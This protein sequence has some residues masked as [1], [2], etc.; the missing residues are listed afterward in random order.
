MKNTTFTAAIIIGLIIAIVS[1]AFALEM[2][3]DLA[4]EQENSNIPLDYLFRIALSFVVTLWLSVLVAL[5]VDRKAVANERKASA[6][7]TKNAMTNMETDLPN[8]RWLDTVLQSETDPLSGEKIII[9]HMNLH[10]LVWFDKVSR[11]LGKSEMEA[12]HT[13]VKN[14]LVT[15]DVTADQLGYIGNGVFFSLNSKLDFP[16]SFRISP[17]NLDPEFQVTV[18][19]VAYKKPSIGSSHKLA[20]DATLIAEKYEAG[21]SEHMISIDASLDNKDAAILAWQAIS[22]GRV[23]FVF[24]PIFSLISGKVKGFEML[25]RLTDH[26]GK[27]IPLTQQTIDIIENSPLSVKFLEFQFQA[28]IHFQQEVV[29]YPHDLKISINVPAP[30]LSRCN[31]DELITSFAVRG[32]NLNCVA[33]ELT[34]RTLLNQ[35]NA[36]MQNLNKIKEHNSEI[37]LDDFGAGQS[38]IEKI[39][40]YPF[41]VVKFDRAFVN[42]QSWSEES[43]ASL[44]NYIKSLGSEV[45]VEG[46]EDKQLGDLFAHCGARYVQ[47]FAYS[48]PLSMKDAIRLI[49]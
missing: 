37:H 17:V 45:L 9:N 12:F 48:Q 8:A 34:E 26:F 38:S 44:I 7:Q 42:N 33:F 40:T 24:Q 23:E 5:F 13:D 1:N 11:Y 6:L 46:I 4:S 39:A 20:Y 32:L 41:D 30:I 14:E 28:V 2:I 31:F 16:D 15:L 36:L 21:N 10:I 27:D 35:S 49:S 19:N 25:A 3:V 18:V 43:A 29:K 22:N 47:G